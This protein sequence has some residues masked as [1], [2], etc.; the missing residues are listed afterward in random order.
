MLGAKLVGEWLKCRGLSLSIKPGK[1]EYTVTLCLLDNPV[2]E[3]K[4]EDAEVALKI[5]MN[6]YDRDPE[7]GR[8]TKA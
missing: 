3:V 1:K 4:D 6:L 5:A 8:V 2:V 7:A